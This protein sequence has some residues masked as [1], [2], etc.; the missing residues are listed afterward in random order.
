MTGL[1]ARPPGGA[2][3]RAGSQVAVA[4]RGYSS[5]VVASDEIVAASHAA[6]GIA[7]VESAHRLVMIADLGN[8]TPPLQSLVRDDDPHGISDSFA[9]GTSF[10]R[11]AREVEGAKNLCVMP[12]GTESAATEAIVS[13]S[14]WGRF[15]SGFANADE[16]LLLVVDS[17]VPGI[18]KLVAQVDG[19]VLVGLQKLDAAPAANILAKIPHPAPTAL[20]RI[21]LT[22]RREAWSRERMALAAAGILALGIAGG[23]IV[24]SSAGSG[25]ASES[26]PAAEPEFISADSAFTPAPPAVR[27]INTADSAIAAAYSVEILAANTSEGANFIIQ[28]NG[29]VMPAVTISLV[30]IGDT[31]AAWYKVYSG[32]Y[33]D[34]T[35]A[36]QLLATL[37][38]QHIVPETEGSIV[39]TPLALLLDSIPSQAGIRSRVR[40]KIQELNSK[41][42]RAYGL[43]QKD[44][45]ARIYAGAFEN[46]EESS[47]AATALRVLGLTPV[48]AYRTGRLP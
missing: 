17:S 36:Q 46:P 16:L 40:E 28:T 18:D 37:R 32:A 44:G 33:E 35:Q 1:G 22:P 7:L 30:P 3:E 6:I 48:L 11:I 5:I 9:F 20:P 39:R 19:V 47:L 12:S 45:S 8:E 29:L 26:V 10:A 38:E 25:T 15:A 24:G 42:V 41:E 14:R 31:E 4:V 2:Y 27:P 34:S 13:S 23:A 43:I 21:D